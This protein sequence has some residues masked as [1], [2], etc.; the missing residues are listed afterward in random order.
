MASGLGGVFE[1]YAHLQP[2]L[3]A[4]LDPLEGVWSYQETVCSAGKSEMSL[5]HP[6]GPCAVPSHS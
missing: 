1:R 5:K 6:R 2:E 4:V 3:P